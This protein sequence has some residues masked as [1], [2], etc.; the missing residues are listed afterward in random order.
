MKAPTVTL[1]TTL[2]TITT[3][4]ALS[5][6]GFSASASLPSQEDLVRQTLYPPVDEEEV[7]HIC[8]AVF[9]SVQ[10]AAMHCPLGSFVIKVKDFWTGKLNGYSCYCDRPDFTE[11]TIH[12]AKLTP[13]N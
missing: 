1:A 10:E 2:A 12:N 13:A 11:D 5:V 6:A 8:F 3:V 4:I 7:P 9:T